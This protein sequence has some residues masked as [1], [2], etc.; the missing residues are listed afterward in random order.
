MTFVPISYIAEY[1][2]T[3]SQVVLGRTKDLLQSV[4][5]RIVAGTQS[6]RNWK[7]NKLTYCLLDYE[8]VS[9]VVDVITHAIALPIWTFIA[10][11]C[12]INSLR[13]QRTSKKTGLLSSRDELL[14]S[15]HLG[16]LFVHNMKILKRSIEWNKRRVDQWCILSAEEYLAICWSKESIL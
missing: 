7:V 14:K 1:N 12:G 2:L 10:A 11:C 6:T 5:G 8:A 16:N 15:F 4:G 13:Y 9:A 3:L